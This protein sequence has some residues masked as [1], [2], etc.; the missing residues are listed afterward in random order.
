M[1]RRVL[2]YDNSKFNA[3][4]APRILAICDC[5]TLIAKTEQEFLSL[6]QTEPV[7]LLIYPVEMQDFL[8]QSKINFDHLTKILLSQSKI[9]DLKPFFG[10]GKTTNI[11]AKKPDGR[12]HPRELITTVNKIFDEN[13]FG[14]QHYVNYGT[15]SEVY[16]IRDS[17]ERSA[18][19]EAVTDF[20]KRM[21]V[22][23]STIQAVEL[24]CEELLMNAIYDAP[25]DENGQELYGQM[26]RKDRVIL[27]PKQ[28]ARMEFACDGEKLVVSVSDPFGAI[29]WDTVQRYLAKCFS[30]SRKVTNLDQGGGAGLGLYFCFNAVNSFVINVNP[31]IR[32]EFIGIFD[33]DAAPKE[34][35]SRYSSIHFFSTTNEDMKKA[36]KLLPVWQAS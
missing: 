16:H 8:D 18:Y 4:N 11:L 15:K 24:F 36:K 30:G 12:I 31:A 14:V 29:T 17:D 19:I 26:S 13:I 35:H 21:H 6:A 5:T 32:S 7:D 9:K 28:A 23:T 33:L 27:K 20:C 2:F 1:A 34:R 25:R 10:E 3:R 22:R